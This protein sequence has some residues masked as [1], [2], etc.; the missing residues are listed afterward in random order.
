V[1][2]DVEILLTH[3]PALNLLDVTRRG[4]HAGCPVLA[5]TLTKLPACRLHVFGH[6]HESHGALIVPPAAGAPEGL[7]R[8]EVNAALEK[9]GDVVIVDLRH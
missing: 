8:V 9:H 1:P 2:T 7:P 5:R 4:K 3:T 6:I